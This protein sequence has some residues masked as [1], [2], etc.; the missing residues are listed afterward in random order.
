MS[1]TLRAAGRVFDVSVGALIWS[2]RTAFMAAVLIVPV[3]LAV[4]GRIALTSGLVPLR[5]NGVPVDGAGLVGLMAWALYLRFIVPVLA[6]FYATGLIAEDVES[7][8]ITY[9]F[10]RPLSRG[11]ILLGKY[12]AYLACTTLVA[13][14]SL[15]LV[16]FLLVPIQAIP[17]S[18]LPLL[19][20]LALVVAGLTTYGALFA[21]AGVLLRRPLLVG[22]LFALG[23]EQL[24]LIMPGY[25]RRLTLAH[26]LQS[27]MPAGLG[28]DRVLAVVEALTPLSAEGLTAVLTLAAI[29]MISLIVA[30]IVVRTREYVLDQ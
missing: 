9:L 3:A 19:G 26:Y 10:T 17:A 15:L 8:T 6:A 30:M 7:R 21:L 13:V 23:W 20:A 12:L 5:V 16:Y 29:T 18:F 4:G 25:L 28:S 27:L 14:P 22:L 2:R 24:A 11:A 1:G